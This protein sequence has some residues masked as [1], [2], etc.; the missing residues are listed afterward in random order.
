MNG[1]NKQTSRNLQSSNKEE[2]VNCKPNVIWLFENSASDT[3]NNL[4]INCNKA[5]SYMSF[6][7][8]TKIYL[9]DNEPPRFWEIL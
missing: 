5:E 2:T 8:L 4:P 7:S 9:L 6:C 1:Q 3:L